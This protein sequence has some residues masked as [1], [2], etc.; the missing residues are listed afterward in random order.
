M[1]KRIKK[2][3]L[4]IYYYGKFKKGNLETLGLGKST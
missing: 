4:Y 2:A 3:F 1:D